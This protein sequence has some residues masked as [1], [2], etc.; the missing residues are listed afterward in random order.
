MQ[1]A[2]FAFAPAPATRSPD[3]GAWSL[4]CLEPGLEAW[5]LEPWPTVDLCFQ[6]KYEKMI[7]L[8]NS[9]AAENPLSIEIY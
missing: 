7:T 6:T 4:E 5:S 8:S 3:H 1:Y 9:D 2:P